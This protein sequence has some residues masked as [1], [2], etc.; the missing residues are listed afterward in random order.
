MINGSVDEPQYLSYLLRLWPVK[1]GGTTVW[2]ASLESSLTGGRTGFSDLE[3]LF[4]FLEHTLLNINLDENI[5]IG[6]ETE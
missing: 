1:I 2:R 6:R 5:Q 3:A 4:S